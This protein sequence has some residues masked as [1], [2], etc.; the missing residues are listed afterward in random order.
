MGDSRYHRLLVEQGLMNAAPAD[1]S[2]SPR[3]TPGEKTAIP[4]NK[5]MMV[6]RELH[7]IA[8]AVTLGNISES[9]YYTQACSRLLEERYGIHR[10]ML[11]NS[12]TSALEIAAMLCDLKAGDEVILPSFTFVS[13]ANALVRLGARPVFVDI[14]QDTL[15]LDENLIEDAITDRTR[16]IVPVHYAGVGCEMTA[17]NQLASDRGLMVVEDAAQG[18][19][20]SYKGQALGSLGDLGTF[21][22]HETKNYV[23]GQGGALCINR[24][25]LVQRAEII[26]DKGTNRQQFL[27]GQVDKYTW[28]EVGSSYVPSEIVAA[29][30]YGQLEAIDALTGLRKR[31]YEA[32][33]RELEP[34]ERAGQLRLPRMPKHCKQNFHMFYVLL[35]DQKT[36]D[37]LMDWLW[38]R[39]ISAVFHY[40]PLHRSPMG[41]RLGTDAKILPL[42]E[43]LSGRLLRLPF[44]SEMTDD[45]RGHVVQAIVEFFQAR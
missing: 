36:R 28:C 20:A 9:G 25:D 18:V 43:D 16:A 19:D 2:A 3:P 45:E 30:L 26:R 1:S 14:R 39:S 24:P 27:R 4:F 32:Y 6:G 17:I 42:T 29:F 15:N 21:S 38:R 41:R 13:T 23:C 40:I 35:E 37:A 22:F 7:H 33:H 31:L 5:P 11:T 8:R 10:V 44:F 34:L 12:C